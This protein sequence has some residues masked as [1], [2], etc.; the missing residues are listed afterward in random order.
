MAHRSRVISVDSIEK[1]TPSLDAEIIFY[2]S[3]VK[4][5][6]KRGFHLM[7]MVL[8]KRVA[9]SI[10]V[11]QLTQVFRMRKKAVISFSFYAESLF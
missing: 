4:E 6:I 3:G 11:N 9:C 8:I 1:I 10:H 7:Q 2:I 5:I